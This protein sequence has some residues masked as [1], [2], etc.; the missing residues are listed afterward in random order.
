MFSLSVADGGRECVLPLARGG[1][2]PVAVRCLEGE[3]E[4][5]C[6]VR[7]KGQIELFSQRNC[8]WRASGGLCVETGSVES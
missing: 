6:V 1:G 2:R 4:E 5:V 3:E 8:S 7:E